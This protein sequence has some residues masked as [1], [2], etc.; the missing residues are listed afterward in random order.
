MPET[1]ARI[2]VCHDT[3]AN[4]KTNNP[5]L[6][7]GEWALETDTKKMKIGDGST[8]YNA[9][10]YSTAEDNDEWIKPDD[11]IDIRSAAL[12][13]S[14]YFLVAHSV[15]TE[16][17]GTYT[18]ATYPQF[19]VRATISNSG[20][21]DVYV[22]GIKVATTDSNTFTTLDWGALYTAGTITTGFNVTHPS[23]LTT[24]VVRMT[25]TIATNT[26]TAIRLDNSISEYGLLWLHFQITNPIGLLYF[27]GSFDNSY[28]CKLLEA[29]TSQNDELQI[30]TGI[31]FRNAVSLKHL[32]LLI[33]QNDSVSFDRGFYNSS[34]LKKIRLKNI[35]LTGNQGF[36]NSN[37]ELF[38]TEN[39]YFQ[40]HN[41]TFQNCVK[42]KRLPP[43][44]F[45]EKT[46]GSNFVVVG[47][48]LQPSVVDARGGSKIKNLGIHGTIENR[49]DGIKVVIVSNEAPFDGAAPQL[50]V[51]Y[52]GLSR[53]AL[54][55]LFKSMPYNV[56]YTVVGSPTIV[57]GVA[58]G[59]SS[60]DKLQMSSLP[61]SGA[62]SVE[63]GI[64]F[65]TGATNIEQGICGSS[66]QFSKYG[67]SITT[68]GLLRTGVR[69]D[70]DGTQSNKNLNNETALQP[71]TTYYAV[72]TCYK[73]THILSLKIST[74]GQN[75]ST[76]SL[77]IGS[78]D[79]FAFLGQAYYIGN[80]QNGA[81]LGS[82][83]LNNTYIKLNG[84]LYF[85]GTA[86]MTKTVSVVG[87]TGT[88]DL[89]AADKAIA[90][91]KGWSITLS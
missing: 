60:D 15:P 46:Y 2:K 70:V 10:P 27:S 44:L 51:A 78:F 77:D 20:T 4:F 42:L 55:N 38:E 63:C 32:P 9:L 14:I 81:F 90:E 30:L 66:L 37:I 83:N 39:A 36:Y 68:D 72:M 64:V 87:C 18:V 47:S 65:T 5:T 52:T 19:K 50:S 62:N 86:A 82:V 24:H 25:P 49:A 53:A 34:S 41:A 13:N 8:A 85:R 91:D 22:D 67:F 76:T 74:D 45:A 61:V 3:A 29:V 1:N 6:L 57:D 89:T 11:W 58:S 16:S 23:T 79:S 71:N 26:I 84:I 43:F 69:V 35:I 73:D 40:N 59:F 54:V 28:S 31:N 33:G 7:V 88:A 80:T 56:G 17:E 12:D 75:W 21:Y 48:A